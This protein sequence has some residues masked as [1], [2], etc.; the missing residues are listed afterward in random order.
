[1]EF[2][3]LIIN[4]GIRFDYFEPDANVLADDEDPNIY[5]PAKLSNTFFDDNGNGIQD[6]TEAPK[7]VADRAKYWYK[8]ATAKVK[9]SP[10]F[11]ASFPITD[12]GVIHFS[13]GH[14]FQTPNFE[15]LY[16][17]PGF[18]V[19]EGTG[20]VDHKG[21]PTGNADLKAIFTPS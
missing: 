20:N 2:K 9:V 5:A 12:R 15:R 7:T 3:D 17:N 16:A 14:F 8:K 4:V 1:M 19:G 6:G 18:K 13:Y 10:R 11:G 21:A